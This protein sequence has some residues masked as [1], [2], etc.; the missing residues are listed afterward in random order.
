MDSFLVTG[1]QFMCDKSTGVPLPVFATSQMAA[2][3]DGKTILCDTDKL[4][5]SFG[6]CPL[7]NP[8]HVCKIA[9]V[10]P[11]WL[12][13][14]PIK[15]GI[16]KALTVKS[17]NICTMGGRITPVTGSGSR[18]VSYD[19][20]CAISDIPDI[21]LD[22]HCEV[23]KPSER[24]SEIPRT[25]N[26]PADISTAEFSRSN[27]AEVTENPFSEQTESEKSQ[28]LSEEERASFLCQCGG[29][30]SRCPSGKFENCK[31]ANSEFRTLQ[32]V[33]SS[34]KLGN[35]IFSESTACSSCGILKKRCSCNP[36]SSKTLQRIEKHIK[37][38]VR[39]TYHHM[40][41]TSAANGVSCFV[42][43]ANYV[44]YDTNRPS[45]GI[46]LPRPSSQDHISRSGKTVYRER[47]IMRI[48]KMQIHRTLHSYTFSTAEA[49]RLRDKIQKLQNDSRYSGER[50]KA[51]LALSP[52]AGKDPGATTTGYFRKVRDLVEQLTDHI[53]NKYSGCC[54]INE[55][56]HIRD[57][58]ETGIKYIED[59]LRTRIS[60]FREDPLFSAPYFL[61][62]GVLMYAYG[63]KTDDG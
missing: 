20:L 5:G 19:R 24:T 28:L 52:S 35:N 48:T 27:P 51:A 31:Y 41:S 29:D 62:L 39:S 56:Q 7:M 47:I 2:T 34:I 14:S 4:V 12:G 58:F 49:Q 59:T 17:Y 13:A 15:C 36:A 43:L 33:N 30:P 38:S 54:F 22:K 40:V 46:C 45:N 18:T 50:Y 42:R 6:A 32:P 23:Y 9:L 10:S 37:V 57:D 60:S 25:R 44:G 53:A 55:E 61:S 26:D 16:N 63:L 1:T 21:Q 3:I 8:D 11:R